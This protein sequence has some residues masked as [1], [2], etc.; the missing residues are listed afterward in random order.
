MPKFIIGLDDQGYQ[1]KNQ[2]IYY[3]QITNQ[4]STPQHHDQI[5]HECLSQIF[6]K[7][8]PDFQ[9]FLYNLMELPVWAT[10]Y[11]LDGPVDY[12]KVAFF[13]D[14]V[15]AFGIFIWHTMRQRAGMDERYFYLLES[16]GPT[17]AI[18]GAYVNADVA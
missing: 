12:D 16:C 2:V 15:R 11:Y 5:Y 7:L 17:V 10:I 18:V 4:P 9:T 8:N 14:A 3:C 1:F 13:R 6:Q